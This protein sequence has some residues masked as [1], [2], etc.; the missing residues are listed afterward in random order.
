M[1]GAILK[2]FGEVPEVLRLV[3]YFP[4]TPPAVFHHYSNMVTPDTR[5]LSLILFLLKYLYGLDDVSE[6]FY[7]STARKFN[8]TLECNV[9]EHTAL[10]R[11]FVIC[12]WLK[13]S[14]RRAFVAARH[15]HL[16]HSSMASLF[17]GV[18]LCDEEI[19]NAAHHRSQQLIQTNKPNKNF[20]RYPK[21]SSG[22]SASGLKMLL[23]DMMESSFPSTPRLSKKLNIAASL[24]PLFD[25]SN[26]VVN[27][28]DC[29]MLSESDQSSIS[30]LLACT[31]CTVDYSAATCGEEHIDLEIPR[32]TAPHSFSQDEGKREP[33]LVQH[34][35]ARKQTALPELAYVFKPRYW[36]LHNRKVHAFSKTF[37]TTDSVNRLLSELPE[38]FCWILEYFSAATS[39]PASEIYADLMVVENMIIATKR[40][41]FGRQN[42]KQSEK[43]RAMQ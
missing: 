16:L 43:S 20:N 26:F 4:S 36:I 38:N 17:P 10:K 9:D 13:L 2:A 5:S 21:K 14:R 29:D 34:Y 12:D 8:A 23:E 37:H 32:R 11:K 6:D 30:T 41:L 1:H 25:F 7:S 24:T 28:A 18:E 40:R 39:V 31:D 15:S 27:D 3:Q 19:V 22:T 42:F 35:V 33:Y